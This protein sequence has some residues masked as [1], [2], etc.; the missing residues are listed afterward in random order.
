MKNK[1]IHGFLALLIVGLLPTAFVS[2][3]NAEKAEKENQAATSTKNITAAVDLQA[4]IEQLQNQI[5]ELQEQ[6][7]KLKT[8]VEEVKEELKLTK[9]LYKGLSDDE[10]KKLQGFLK[11]YAEVYPEGLVTGYYGP[12]TE[13]AVKKFQ[14]QHDIPVTGL[15]GPATREKIKELSSEKKVIVCHSPPENPANKHTLEI[16][17]SALS[18][19]LA[20]GDTVGVCIGGLPTSAPAPTSTLPTASPAPSAPSASQQKFSLQISANTATTQ[21]IAPGTVNAKVVKFELSAYSDSN[22]VINKLVVAKKGGSAGC[23]FDNFKLYDYSRALPVQVGST[24]SPDSECRAVFSN[25]NL[26]IPKD[27]SRV[28]LMLWVDVISSARAG[29]T[30]YLGITE[31]ECAANTCSLG[32]TGLPAYGPQ[33][34]I[35]P[36]VL[37]TITLLS[38]TGGEI[39]LTGQPYTLKW[40]TANLPSNAKI[41]VTFLLYVNYGTSMSY[42]P[43][44]L[45]NLSDDGNETW[46]TQASFIPGEYKVLVSANYEL[47]GYYHNVS[48]HSELISIGTGKAVAEPTGATPAVPK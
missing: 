3:E 32:I 38:P 18:A 33:M 10:V 23:Y 22:V 39:W 12:L 24:I 31:A 36:P 5:K 40:K 48:H 1:I 26:A 4:L 8:D 25:L 43:P 37:P 30:F 29:D 17:E 47:S 27:L 21:N 44:E 45:S 7:A 42:S 16:G 19:H 41:S 9:D 13:K 15:V 35:T 14:E 28:S 2:A 46:I 20:H 11:Q 6:I 34:T